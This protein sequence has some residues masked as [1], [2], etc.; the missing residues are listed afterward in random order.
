LQ[1]N[2]KY[3]EALNVE[4]NEEYELSALCAGPAL[5]R[6]G[7]HPAGANPGINTTIKDS[8]SPRPARPRPSLLPNASELLKEAPQKVLK[9]RQ[10]RACLRWTPSNSWVCSRMRITKL[11]L[12]HSVRA[13]RFQLGYYHQTQKRFEKKIRTNAAETIKE[14]N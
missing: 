11:S 9:R 1:N 8:I 10:A 2:Q 3:R 7:G 14:E 6:A 4:L 13:G 5:F 12:H